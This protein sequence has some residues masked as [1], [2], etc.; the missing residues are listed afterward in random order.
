MDD[1]PLESRAIWTS[2]RRE[3]LQKVIAS[4]SF[5]GLAVPSP[6]EVINNTRIS[7]PVHQMCQWLEAAEQSRPKDATY[8]AIQSKPDDIPYRIHV[9]VAG[10]TVSAIV[11]RVRILCC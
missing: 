8:L 6:A 10:S 2:P 5:Q 4:K 11:K 3:R 7:V 9:D 1:A